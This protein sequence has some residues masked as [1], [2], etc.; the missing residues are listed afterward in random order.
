[1][2]GP[3][4]HAGARSRQK[5]IS[6]GGIISDDQAD[7]LFELSSLQLFVHAYGMVGGKKMAETDTNSAM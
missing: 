3:P 7:T 5:N 6:T 2:F 4:A 1:M